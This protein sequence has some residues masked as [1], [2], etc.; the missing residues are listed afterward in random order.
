MCGTRFGLQRGEPLIGGVPPVPP[1]VAGADHLLV[2][3]A[4]VPQEDVGD[5]PPVPVPARGAHHDGLRECEARRE[6][7]GSLA[8]CLFLLGGIDPMQ[9]QGLV[10]SVAQNRDRVTVRD[11]DYQR[12]EVFG[13]SGEGKTQREE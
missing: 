6:L 12:T 1:R 11:A 10:A 9:T 2:E 5:R 13:V 8:E 4:P 3:V 7:L